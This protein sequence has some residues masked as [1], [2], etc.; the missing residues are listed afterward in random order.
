M[1]KGSLRD[2]QTYLSNLTS[3]ASINS[4]TLAFLS[5]ALSQSSPLSSEHSKA[6]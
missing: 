1:S 5:P 3:Q 4:I 6:F 2:S